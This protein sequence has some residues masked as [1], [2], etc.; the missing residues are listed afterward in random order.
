M[1][2][3]LT[4][5]TVHN[6]EEKLDLLVTKSESTDPW[7]AEDTVSWE[8]LDS[9]LAQGRAAAEAKCPAKRTGALPWSPD[10]DCAGKRFL[11]WKICLREFTSKFTNSVTLERLAGEVPIAADDQLWLSFKVV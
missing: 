5:V 7:T 10:L 1:K 3:L 8:Q 11:Y 9:I 6:I 4:H 2:H